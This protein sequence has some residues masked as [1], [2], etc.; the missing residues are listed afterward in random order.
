MNL[1]YGAATGTYTQFGTSGGFSAGLLAT[2]TNPIALNNPTAPLALTGLSPV[3]A[4]FVG[5]VAAI[6][7]PGPRFPT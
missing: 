2:I 6:S 5:A 7:M 3:S 1:F 4:S